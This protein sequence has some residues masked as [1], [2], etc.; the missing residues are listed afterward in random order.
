MPENKPITFAGIHYQMKIWKV[1][2]KS[3][4]SSRFKIPGLEEI[5]NLN[6]LRWRLKTFMKSSEL[7][8]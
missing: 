3:L 6:S 5:K 1:N 7:D 2:G 8:I 4:T